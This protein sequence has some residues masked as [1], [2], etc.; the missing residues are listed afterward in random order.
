VEVFDGT[1]IGVLL[2]RGRLVR[3]GVTVTKCLGVDVSEGKGVRDRV[4]VGTKVCVGTKTVTTC[5][6]SAAAVS[7]LETAKSTMFNGWMVMMGRKFLKSPI[8]IAETLQSRLMPI[9][10]AARTPTGPA[11]SRAFNPV[12][13]LLNWE[14]GYEICCDE[15]SNLNGWPSDIEIISQNYS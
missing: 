9:T 2:G 7:R 6:V 11:Y 13:L 1:T 5:S 4:A 14:D 15:F 8:A 3:V 10:P 12:M